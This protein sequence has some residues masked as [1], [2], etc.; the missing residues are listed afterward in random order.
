MYNIKDPLVLYLEIEQ[1]QGKRQIVL[2]CFKWG[3]FDAYLLKISY[4]PT[5]QIKNLELKYPCIFSNIDLQYYMINYMIPV[6]AKK[7][8]TGTFKI[9]IEISLFKESFFKLA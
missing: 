4:T 8:P 1:Q 9:H 7:S 3:L 6:I 2:T 5:L